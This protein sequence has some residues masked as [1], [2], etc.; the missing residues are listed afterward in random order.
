MSQSP[1][2]S[3][4]FV[5]LYRAGSLIE[6]DELV[7]ELNEAGIPTQVENEL[8]QGGLGELPPGWSTLPRIQ[9][10]ESLASE[11]RTILSQVQAAVSSNRPQGNCCLAC[12]Q[13]MPNQNV[14]ENCGWSWGDDSDVLT[15]E[16]SEIAVALPSPDGSHLSQDGRST[17]KEAS[18]VEAEPAAKPAREL[19]I[20]LSVVLAIS[21]VPSLEGAL[22]S[23]FEPHSQS[24][25]SEAI[26]LFLFSVCS[27]WAV[28]YVIQ[29][30]GESLTNFGIVRPQIAD[31]V[32]GI[33][34]VPFIDL[35][36]ILYYDLIPLSVDVSPLFEL[37]RPST[38]LDHVLMVFSQF[39][40]AFHEELVLRAYLI[41]RLCTLLKYRRR[42]VVVAAAIFASYHIYHG[43]IGAGG[44]FFFGIGFGVLWLLFRRL[45]PLV[46]GHALS[47]IVI[48]AFD[49]WW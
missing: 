44:V 9:V 20:E 15:T 42:A 19:W 49:W 45:W 23:I 8:L 43:V 40:N 31:I 48:E 22:Q 11:A 29:R 33:L 24:Y 32:A 18:S 26:S 4:E 7:R 41:T 37:P 16:V 35:S 46:I 1:N 36:W 6:A 34:I 14:C 13:P 27:A 39:A 25:A 21:V 2:D 3:A 30:N 17:N 47:N 38:A 5:E 28:V 10:P 12:N